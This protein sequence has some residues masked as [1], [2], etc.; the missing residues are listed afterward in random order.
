MDI[1]VSWP[2]APTQRF[3]DVTLRSSHYRGAAARAGVAVRHAHAAKQRRYGNSVQALAIEVGG[4]M[5]PEAIETLRRLAFESQTGR[6]WHAR[7]SPKLHAHGPPWSQAGAADPVC[8]ETQQKQP[9]LS[10]ASHNASQAAP[11]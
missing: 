2:L 8:T 9:P 3:L 4:R 6:R 7:C 11:A 1:A 5:L 10:A